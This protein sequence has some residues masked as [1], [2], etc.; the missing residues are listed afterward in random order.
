[1]KVLKVILI[2]LVKDA[3]SKVKEDF[4]V[5]TH[6]SGVDQNWHIFNF[7]QAGTKNLKILDEVQLSFRLK[8]NFFIK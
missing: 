4:R 2:L 8:L 3:M 5:K 1:M 7:V 6:S